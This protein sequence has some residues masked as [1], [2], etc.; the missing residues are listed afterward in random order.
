MIDTNDAASYV[1][2]FHEEGWLPG[3]VGALAQLIVHNESSR[4]IFV[5]PE[6]FDASSLTASDFFTLRDLYGSQE[7]QAPVKGGTISRWASSLFLLLG[8][9]DSRCAAFVSTINASLLGVKSLEMWRS[10]GGHPNQIRLG[11]WGL[12]RDLGYPSLEAILPVIDCEAEDAMTQIENLYNLHV[13]TFPAILV[14]NYGLLTW[15][16]TLP[17]LKNKIEL[18]ERLFEL[19]LRTV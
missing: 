5:T 9:T 1:K 7:I 19:Q 17:L 18:L 15:E 2:K 12:L 8:K 10:Q 4:K 6:H 14:R 11:R 13:Q 16:K 3:S